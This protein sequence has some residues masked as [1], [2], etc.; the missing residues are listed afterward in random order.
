MVSSNPLVSFEEAELNH[1]RETRSWSFAERI[2]WLESMTRMASAMQIRNVKNL[3]EKHPYRI[4]IET[5]PE[6]AKAILAD[7]DIYLKSAKER[8]Q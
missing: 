8:S 2:Q 6:E 1:L 4:W 3:P 5:H 7:N